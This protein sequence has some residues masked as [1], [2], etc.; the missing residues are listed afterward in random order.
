MA[1]EVRIFAPVEEPIPVDEIYELTGSDELV[2]VTTPDGELLRYEVP[3]E[4]VTLT[5]TFMPLNEVKAYIQEIVGYATNLLSDREDRKARKVIRRLKHMQQVMICTIEPDWD[6]AG[7]CE[8]LVKGI[9]GYFD[10]AF[11]YADGA[12]YNE[13]GNRRMGPEDSKMKYFRDDESIHSPN[14]VA[15]KNR[16]IKQLKKEGVPTIKHLPVIQDEADTTL[17]SVPETVKRV[18]VLML[19]ADRAEGE[20]IASSQERMIQYGLTEDD[21]SPLEWGFINN[22]EPDDY[23][24]QF[25][26]Q[27]YEAAWTLLWTLRFV[28]QLARPDTYA[29][30]PQAKR[31]LAE[32]STDTLI[33]EAQMRSVSEILDMADLTYRYHWA[34]MDAMLYGNQ[35]PTGLKPPVAYERHYALN[36]LIG[37][38]DQAWDDVTTDT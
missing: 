28:N 37:Y 24:Y 26:G 22:P 12:L 1:E 13:N 19:V 2:V 4:D 36:W 38:Q 18:I 29:D 30:V 7:K 33:M 31:I 10:Y 20:S 11:M 17:R 6:A 16:T 15:R 14:A 34:I 32:R 8:N 23:E 3:W 35:P 27:R 25:Y 9:V 5:I 21:F